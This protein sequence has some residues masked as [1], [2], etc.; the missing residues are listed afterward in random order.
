MVGR[1]RGRGNRSLRTAFGILRDCE[2]NRKPDLGYGQLLA[3]RN[4][5]RWVRARRMA[6]LVPA[7]EPAKR[8][9]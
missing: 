3:K 1:S 4:T 5:K 2:P 6:G 8:A 7:S 9:G